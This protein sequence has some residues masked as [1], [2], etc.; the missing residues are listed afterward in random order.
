[1]GVAVY[2]VTHQRYFTYNAGNPFLMGSS[3][4]VPIMLEYFDDIQALGRAPT[5]DEVSLLSAMIENSDNDAAQTLYAAFDYDA[6]LSQLLQEDGVA[7]F[8]ASKD[9]FGWYAITP[10][11]MV[12]LL[13]RIYQA[14]GLTTQDQALALNLME[15][16]ESD[17]QQG[18][19]ETA[20][21]R[22]T[23]AMKDGW[24]QGPDGGWAVNSSGIVYAPGVTYIVA[25]YTQD[26]ASLDDGYALLDQVCAH[27]SSALVPVVP[28]LVA[29]DAG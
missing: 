2:D 4:K 10:R 17:Q 14:Q 6:G 15:N 27:L 25:V 20:P 18:L 13:T 8:S 5:A 26:D 19:G 23:V 21:S 1:M 28:R 22:A 16:V 7:T 3:A 29:G 9:G 24:L 11:G 12:H